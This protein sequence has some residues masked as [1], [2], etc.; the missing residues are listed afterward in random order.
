MFTVFIFFREDYVMYSRLCGSIL[1]LAHRLAQLPPKD[2]FRT[3][4]EGSL[5]SKLYDMAIVD[6]GAKV[7]DVRDGKKVTVSAF[8]R[9]RLAVVVCKLKMSQTVKMVMFRELLTTAPF[10][11]WVADW[12]KCG[13]LQTGGA[14]HRARTYPRRPRHNHR[15]CFSSHSVSVTPK[16][17][18][19]ITDNTS[20]FSP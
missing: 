5:L 3:K 19:Y 15:S 8:C 11:F 6:I 1:S 2:P 20:F 10:P 7:E 9:R 4:Y 17:K 13:E 12:R 18:K 14:I 16:R